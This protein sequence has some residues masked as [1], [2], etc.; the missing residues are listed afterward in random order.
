MKQIREKDVNWVVFD[1]R[2]NFG[3]SLSALNAAI[4]ILYGNSFVKS[5][6]K[7]VGYNFAISQNFI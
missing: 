2:N 3:G 5:F 7:D 1:M 4:H 6:N